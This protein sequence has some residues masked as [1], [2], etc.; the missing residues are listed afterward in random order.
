MIPPAEAIRQFPRPAVVV[1][2]CLGFAA[3]RYDG[4]IIRDDFVAALKAHVTFVPVCPEVEIGLG[5]PRE[6]VRVVEDETGRRLV[7]PATGRD[8]T[9]RMRRFAN[10]FLGSLEAVDGFILKSRSPSSGIKDVK[11]YRSAAKGAAAG[12]GAG[13]FG[14]AVLES[15]GHLAVEDEGRLK[16]LRLREHFLTKLFALASFRALKEASALKDLIRFHA[17]NKLLLMAYNQTKMRALGRGVAN[18][19]HQPYRNVLAAYEP[20]YYQAL[21]RP[22]RYSANI[23]VLMHGLGH[24]SKN[25]GARE[26]AFFLDE[27]EQYR[28]GRVPLSVPLAVLRGYAVRFADEYITRQTYFSPYPEELMSRA[29][30]ARGADTQL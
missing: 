27:L 19:E 28:A 9:A 22:P 7:Q 3:V 14:G 18:A 5:I 26:K 20:E 11:T 8:V 13:F 24:F 10:A 16:N 4:S 29:D 23:N 2:E 15:F 12:K 30:S 6:P 1:S 17:D 21:A 25:L